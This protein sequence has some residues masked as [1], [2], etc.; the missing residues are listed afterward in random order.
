[1][2]AAK[3]SKVVILSFLIGSIVIGVLAYVGMAIGGNEAVALIHKTIEERGGTVAQGG[4]MAVPLDESP[5]EK[6][7]KGNTIFKIDYTKDGKTYTAFYRSKNQSSII[8]EQE[9]WIFAE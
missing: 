8:S 9:E 7:G 3:K 2:E 1:M 4:I 5:F 6:S